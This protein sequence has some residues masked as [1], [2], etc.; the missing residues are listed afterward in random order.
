MQ[1]GGEEARA[2]AVASRR[3]AGGA[4]AGP[5]MAHEQRGRHHAAAPHIDRPEPVRRGAGPTEWP[6]GPLCYSQRNYSPT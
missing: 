4:A 2:K 3:F 1:A 5:D 6:R